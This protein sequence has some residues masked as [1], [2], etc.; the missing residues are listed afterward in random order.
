M[1]ID[2]SPVARVSSEFLDYQYEVLGL[3]RLVSRTRTF[4]WAKA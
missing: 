2:N 3:I 4:P 1:D